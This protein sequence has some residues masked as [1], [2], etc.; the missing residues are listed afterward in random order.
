MKVFTLPHT[1]FLTDAH[2][3]QNAVCNSIMW[4]WHNC[5][6]NTTDSNTDQ[7]TKKKVFYTHFKKHTLTYAHSHNSGTSHSMVSTTFH[8]KDKYSFQF[9]T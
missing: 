5:H 2:V 4:K 9:I 1:H 6:W 7:C 3:F 8:Y